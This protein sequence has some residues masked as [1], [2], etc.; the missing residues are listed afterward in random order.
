[1]VNVAVTTPNNRKKA[2][3]LFDKVFTPWAQENGETDIPEEYRFYDK[4]YDFAIQQSILEVSGFLDWHQIERFFT[5]ST[6]PCIG[7]PKESMYELYRWITARVCGLPEHG[8]IFLVPIYSTNKE[9]EKD[10]PM[11]VGDGV[12]LKAAYE[13]LTVVD[14]EGL[15]WEQVSQFKSD[16][17]A[18]KRYRDF[19]LWIRE[20]N[21]VSSFNH[22]R[23][24]L[25]QRLEDY[26]WAIKKHGLSTILGALSTIVSSQS[27]VKS[28]S[29]GI[30]V[31]LVSQ[32]L[33]GMLSA[34]LI[35]TSDV[36]I[37]AAKYKL[38][39]EDIQR[40]NREVALVYEAKKIIDRNA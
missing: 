4:K 2:A 30:S 6:S 22:A 33:I 13:N 1:M 35:L 24:L 34:G 17:V 31:S 14:E 21:N 25:S 10:I 29:V 20:L 19:R 3:L 40:K 12:F 26:E 8:G 27:L 36:L 38:E 16:E 23:D 28:G 7:Y 39:K 15:E 37:K 18:S 5:P 32:P 9:L 11:S